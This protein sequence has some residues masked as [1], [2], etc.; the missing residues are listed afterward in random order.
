MTLAGTAA[1]KFAQSVQGLPYIWGGTGPNGYDCSG[2][3]QKAWA[4]AGVKLP[5]TSQEQRNAGSV[6]PLSQAQPGDLVLFSSPGESDNPAPGNHVGLYV[7][8]STIFAAS[9]TGI[10]IGFAPLDV[11]HLDRVVRPG[12]SA[13]AAGAAATSSAAL[14]TTMQPVSDQ[15][16]A[17]LAGYQA[18]VNLTPWG[19]P[20]NPLKLPGYLGGK[21]GSLAGSAG[22]S[23]I[24]GMLSGI[25]DALG[26]LLLTLVIAGGGLTLIALGVWKAGQ[27]ARQKAQAA[28][29]DV[30]QVA[31]LAAL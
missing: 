23:V 19:L 29:G 7:N 18:V 21:L 12:G 28:A 4:V 9:K 8:P 2:L 11:A 15:P 27:P 26:P 22:S 25:V 24:G 31:A 14:N 3:T 13:G 6:I 30:A 1:L 17:Q 16:A 10:P 20:L 5:R